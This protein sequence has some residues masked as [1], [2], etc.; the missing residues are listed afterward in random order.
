M[1]FSSVQFFIFFPIVTVAYFLLP[2]RYRWV[3]LLTVSCFF[4]MFFVPKYIFILLGTIVVDYIAGIL[5]EGAPSL[6]TRKIY[7]LLSIISNLGVLV[8]F[9]YYA[10][11]GANINGLAELLHWNYSL[12]AL[13]IL[14]PI[15]LSFHTF[16]AMSYTIEVYRGKQKAERHLGIY[17]LYVMFYPQLV[18]GPIER[19]QNMLHQ[20]HE[21]HIFDRQ[22]VAS[23]LGLMLTGLFK[24]IVIADQLAIV[25]NRVFA[26]PAAY[27]GIPLLIASI[28]FTVQIYC[29]FSGYSEIAVG[30][31]R[32]MGFKLMTNF[33]RPYLAKNMA[34]FWQRWHI[35]LSSW[36]RDYVYIPLGGNRYGRLRKCLNILVVFL[37]SGLWH[38]AAWTFIVWGALH[39]LYRVTSEYSITLRAK[40]SALFKTHRFTGWHTAFARM[41]TLILVSVAFIFFRAASLK[42]ALFIVT[43]LFTGSALLF[44]QVIESGGRSM[45]SGTFLGYF[46][47][48]DRTKFMVIVL[49]VFLLPVLESTY[50]LTADQTVYVAPTWSRLRRWALYYGLLIALGAL[51]VFVTTS[52]FIYFQF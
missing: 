21:R 13:N 24:K 26:D 39:G 33:N 4:Y 44:R 23:G 41:Y 42:E 37:L 40:L 31:A 15:G 48:V 47:G 3:L 45:F 10:F 32:V 38:G 27:T 25:V 6:R 43:H 17:A 14:L 8:F 12:P 5:I 11:L 1:S 51:G 52:S 28:F 29:D 22:Q 30:A 34:E 7:L 19:P 16:Q 35:S 2:H 9:K 36:F 46:L 50:R 18:A 49:L 20:F